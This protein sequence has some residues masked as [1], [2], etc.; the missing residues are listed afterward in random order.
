MKALRKQNMITSVLLTLS[1]L[2]ATFAVQAGS[3]YDGSVP[4]SPNGVSSVDGVTS[5]LAN[6]GPATS[7]TASDSIND[8]S[9]VRFRC[10]MFFPPL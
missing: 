3:D 2:I 6:T 8:N 9:T 10:F 1:M 5:H 4:P 7:R